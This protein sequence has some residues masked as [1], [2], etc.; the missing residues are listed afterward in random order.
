MHQRGDTKRQFFNRLSNSFN[1]NN[2]VPSICRRT[3]FVM[4]V[5]DVLIEGYFYRTSN[6]WRDCSGF[7]WTCSHV[8][9]QLWA[10]FY[11]LKSIWNRK[12]KIKKSYAEKPKEI[13]G[14]PLNPHINFSQKKKKKKEHCFFLIKCVLQLL[15]NTRGQRVW[16]IMMHQAQNFQRKC[17]F[18][19]FITGFS[20]KW[21]I[22][23]SEHRG[24]TE[25]T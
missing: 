21:R 9:L 17:S 10:V 4:N 12:R 22:A 19:W 11:I 3:L 18:T 7:L 20:N 24:K 25:T 13:N 2:Q 8:L 5:N 1:H 6:S 15:L 14:K 16:N 23:A